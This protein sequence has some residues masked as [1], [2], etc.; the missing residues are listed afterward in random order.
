VKVRHLLSIAQLSP[1]EVGKILDRAEE[2]KSEHD[3]GKRYQPLVGK[4]LG[5]LFYKSS[6]RTRVSFEVAM[7]QLGGTSLLFAAQDLQLKRGESIADTARTLSRYL[8]AIVIR[9][10]AHQEIESWASEATIPVIN[11]LTDLH[12]PCQALGDLL[13]M[14]ERLGSL[15]DLVLAYIG[16]GNNVAHSLIEGAARTGMSIRLACPKGYGPKTPI[17]QAARQVAASTGARIEVLQ[18]PQKAARQADILYT[19]VWVS[20]GQERETKRR[21]KILKPYQI[22]NALLRVAKPTA[23]VMHCLPA[24][25]GR[26]ITAEVL[27][28][29]QS[30]VW[31]QAENRLHAQKAVLEWLLL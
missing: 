13:T 16:D 9:T 7:A 23:C 21:E 20:M 4:T 15:K 8:N 18:D 29:P 5:L 22:N 6:T 11:G 27:D 10:Y 19:D 3:E 31:E 17:V 28:G 30:I 25:R 1:A 14:K 12:H 24:Y 2:L 26:E